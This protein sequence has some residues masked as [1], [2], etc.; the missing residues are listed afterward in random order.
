MINLENLKI[1][2]IILLGISALLILIFSLISKKPFKTLLLNVLI[3]IMVLAIINLT[4]KY[5]GVRI[6]INVYTVFGCAVLGIP[7][8]IGFLVLPFIFL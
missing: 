2:V 7:A 1:Y 6:P 4:E 3:G 5:S 8:I